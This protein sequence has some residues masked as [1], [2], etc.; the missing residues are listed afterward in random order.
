MPA[1][2]L[3]TRRH[4]IVFIVAQA[5]F[6]FLLAACG[7]TLPTPSPGPTGTILQ[8]DIPTAVSSQSPTVPFELYTQVV[9]D[10]LKEEKTT[11]VYISPYAGQ[12]E[13]LDVPDEE[14]PLP[15]TLVPALERADPS[16]DYEMLDFSEAIGPLEEGGVVNEDGVF[17]TLGPI[18]T[19]QADEIATVRA[20]IYRRVGSAEGYIYRFGHDAGD[21]KL[22]EA[23]QEWSD[24]E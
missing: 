2:S 7:T 23:E 4:A 10:L 9:L 6:A 12:S 21:W 22:L 1:K 11:R 16:R 13:R 14:G 15:P 18:A 17:V 24:E 3:P 20:S 5:L 8:E 19:E